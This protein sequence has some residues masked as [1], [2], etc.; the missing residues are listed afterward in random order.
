MGNMH[1]HRFQHVGIVLSLT[2]VSATHT[3]HPCNDSS[4]A[5]A[6]AMRQHIEHVEIVCYRFSAVSTN[7]CHWP[8]SME[9]SE[10]QDPAG[11]VPN[12]RDGN[13]LN[14]RGTQSVRVTRDASKLHRI[15]PAHRRTERKHVSQLVGVMPWSRDKRAS[16][17][18]DNKFSII[19]FWKHSIVRGR[20]GFR[21]P[22]FLHSI[23]MCSA[24]SSHSRTC[25]APNTTRFTLA[26]ENTSFFFWSVAVVVVYSNSARMP[27]RAYETT[28]NR[29][30]A[31]SSQRCE[32]VN[33]LGT[34]SRARHERYVPFHIFISCG[35]IGARAHWIDW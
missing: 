10:H 28:W 32:C 11:R 2:N 4:A 26:H 8:I 22:S 21:I 6:H 35:K 7:M 13:Q 27:A 17:Y 25:R 18:I 20:S 9:V 16:A 30:F 14:E 24:H 1:K 29:L 33:K 3:P 31:L 5:A 15:S 34:E 19:T 23:A 12:E